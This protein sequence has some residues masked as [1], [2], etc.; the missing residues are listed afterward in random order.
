[1]IFRGSAFQRCRCF[2]ETSD[3]QSRSDGRSLN[4]L[5]VHIIEWDFYF[6]HHFYFHKSFLI[7]FIQYHRAR[8]NLKNLREKLFRSRHINQSQSARVYY[9][10]LIFSFILLLIFM[11][12]NSSNW[13]PTRAAFPLDRSFRMF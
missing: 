9:V 3:V 13:P 2:D 7:T 4:S 1:M 6:Q 12:R 5:F 10:R 8:R 11:K